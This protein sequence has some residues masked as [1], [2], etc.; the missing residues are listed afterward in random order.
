MLYIPIYCFIYLIKNS[1]SLDQF[2]SGTKGEF[3]TTLFHLIAIN[4]SW[5]LLT[6][7]GKF[8]DVKVSPVCADVG[9]A[10]APKSPKS[11]NIAPY[12]HMIVFQSVSV[13]IDSLIYSGLA[14]FSEGYCTWVFSNSILKSCRPVLSYLSW[15]VLVRPN[16]GPYLHMIGLNYVLIHFK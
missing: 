16:I 8:P 6:S 4:V 14:D 10:Q 5:T 15:L 3:P 7:I 11:P 12:H 9:K 2:E 1:N 13:C